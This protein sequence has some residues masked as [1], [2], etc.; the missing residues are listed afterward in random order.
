MANDFKDPDSLYENDGRGH[1]Q[2]TLSYVV[3][4]TPHSSIG[5]DFGD[6]DNNG[7][8]DFLV[9]DMI[10]TSRAKSMR[11]MAHLRANMELPRLHPGGAPQLMR[12][13]LYLNRDGRRMLEAA[14]LTGLGA[15]DWT[16]TV[17]LEDFDNDSDTDVWFTNG[18]VRE[19]H[20]TDITGRM[21]K[22]ESISA[23]VR[24]MRGTP[25]LAEANLAFRNDGNLTVTD[26]STP[27]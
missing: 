23:R 2:N 15:S 19:F 6:L 26:V 9:A 25:L 11:G 27:W 22:Q 7:R 20:S 13:A 14:N 18:M 16:W 10:A 17:R 8:T 3:P 5:T 21:Q 24:I 4:H 1:F 12:N